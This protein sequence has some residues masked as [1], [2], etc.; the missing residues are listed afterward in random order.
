MDYGSWVTQDCCETNR[1]T[2]E[3]RSAANSETLDNTALENQDFWKSISAYELSCR[4]RRWNAAEENKMRGHKYSLANGKDLLTG[5]RAEDV[6]ASRV[7]G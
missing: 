2:K 4:N 6:L 3:A 1:L 7:P 5:N